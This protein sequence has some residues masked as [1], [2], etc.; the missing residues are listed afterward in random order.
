MNNL[1][2]GEK[3]PETLKAVKLEK[4]VLLARLKE[5]EVVEDIMN[6]FSSDKVPLEAVIPPNDS[7]QETVRV[8]GD[9]LEVV[10]KEVGEN[11]ELQHPKTRASRS[12]VYVFILLKD[13]Y[14]SVSPEDAPHGLKITKAGEDRSPRK[15]VVWTKTE[16]SYV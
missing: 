9:D 12:D 14:I 6:R 1:S 16:C 2:I 15:R 11:W 7:S 10:V 4:E 8:F 5:L 13:L 3:Y